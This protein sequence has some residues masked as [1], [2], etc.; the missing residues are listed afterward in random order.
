MALLPGLAFPDP[1]FVAL[2]SAAVIVQLVSPWQPAAAP[3]SRRLRLRFGGEAG[4]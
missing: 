4:Q 1:A 2:V 3:P